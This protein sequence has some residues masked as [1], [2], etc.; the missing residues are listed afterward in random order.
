[1]IRWL[2]LRLIV[3]WIVPVILI[4]KTAMTIAMPIRM[5]MPVT[6]PVGVSV[7]VNVNIEVD[8]NIEW[9]WYCYLSLVIILF[10]ILCEL[11]MSGYVPTKSQ[12]STST[13]LCQKKNL[14]P[15]WWLPF[16]INPKNRKST[17]YWPFS[18]M[19]LGAMVNNRE[20]RK[21]KWFWTFSKPFLFA[22]WNVHAL[23][24]SNKPRARGLVSLHKVTY[25]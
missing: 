2:W 11:N 24:T 14:N 13:G 6:M 25:T 23:K 16:K 12:A 10:S 17:W 4:V 7:S 21:V 8:I 9:C 5:T 22:R 18:R 15:L 19:V 1:M 3:T 20:K